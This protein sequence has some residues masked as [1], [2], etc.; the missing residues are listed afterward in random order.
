[1]K[2]DK[3]KIIIILLNIFDTSFIKANFFKKMLVVY[4]NY[5]D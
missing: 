2:T 3:S 4:Y 5:N 1:M